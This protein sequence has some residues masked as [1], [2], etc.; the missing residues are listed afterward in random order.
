MRLLVDW[1]GW[2]AH[3]GSWYCSKC[4]YTCQHLLSGLP[5]ARTPPGGCLAA[6]QAGGK[7]T[8]LV[9]L[10]RAWQGCTR[11]AP[12]RPFPEL[13]WGLSA[14]PCAQQVLGRCQVSGW[15]CRGDAYTR[16]V[17]GP[18]GGGHKLYTPTLKLRWA[19]LVP[20]MGTQPHRAPFPALPSA[21]RTVTFPPSYPACIAAATSLCPNP[22]TAV[23][24]RGAAWR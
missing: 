4:S 13:Q 11:P 16:G 6:L 15:T 14:S 23:N 21:A 24:S 10:Q 18:L 5:G 2:R 8:A 20:T 3:G 19:L 17:R 1:R 22:R 7:D 9:T 12:P